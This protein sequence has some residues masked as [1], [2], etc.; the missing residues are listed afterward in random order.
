MLTIKLG[1]NVGLKIKSYINSRTK[2]RGAFF[3]VK[4]INTVKKSIKVNYIED[5]TIF[6]ITM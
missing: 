1:E 4:A 6:I 5:K 3:K 2:K